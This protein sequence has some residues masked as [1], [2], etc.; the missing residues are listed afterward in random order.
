MILCCGEALIDM[1]P[2]TTTLGEDAYAPYAGGAIFNTAIALGRLGV[3][4]GFFT[5]LSDDMMGDILR[6]T[7]GESGVDYS[8]CATLS[9]P[10]T[11][12]FVKLV[13]GHASYAFYDEG[14]AGRMITEAEL[15]LLG[16]D[17]EALHF[18]AISLIPEPCGSTY[19]ALLRREHE[20]R[21]ISLDPN[22]RPGFI[23]DKDAHLGRIRR[24]AAMADIVKFSD[25]D[26]AWFGLE[27][28]EEALARHWLHHG[29]K[30]VVVTRGAQGAV[31][32]SA[33]HKVIVPSERVSVVDT[34]GAGDTFDAGVL[35]SLKMQ[36]LLTKYQVA[37]LDED[38]IAKV[39]ALGAKAAAVTVSRAG[40]NPPWA[41]EIG[42]A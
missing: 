10:T 27:G 42:L 33:N 39:L 28:D 22:I 19:E 2:R 17:C 34:V 24:M 14:T 16:D 6:R 8:Y 41:K 32:Y 1:L 38:Q 37:R 13:D 9:R 11:V 30:L 5:G 29:A 20:K 36:N 21:V 23:K 12:A 15:P 7:L 25:E 3:P 18:G 26:L 4:T 40:A 35:A 31:G